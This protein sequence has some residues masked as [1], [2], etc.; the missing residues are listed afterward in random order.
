MRT[1]LSLLSFRMYA[2]DTHQLIVPNWDRNVSFHTVISL[3]A[4]IMA[5]LMGHLSQMRT[6]IA[7]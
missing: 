7:C 1:N 4:F 3:C 5:A 6:H 2:L